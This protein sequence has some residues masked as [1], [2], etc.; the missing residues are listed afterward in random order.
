MEGRDDTLGGKDEDWGLRGELTDRFDCGVG[1][2]TA[3]CKRAEA[4]MLELGERWCVRTVASHLGL[5]RGSIDPACDE[6]NEA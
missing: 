2:R 5:R 1:G 3:T 4:M 6:R